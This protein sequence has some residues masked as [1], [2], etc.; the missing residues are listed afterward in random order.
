MK[1][2]VVVTGVGLVTPLGLGV[3]ANWDSLVSGSSGIRKISRFDATGYHCQV[4]GEVCGFVPELVLPS[5]P[6]QVQASLCRSGEL[7]PWG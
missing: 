6:G 5:G 3:E 2:R 1:R 4:A 7:S